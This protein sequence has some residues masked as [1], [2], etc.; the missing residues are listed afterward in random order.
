MCTGREP[1]TSQVYSMKKVLALVLSTIGA[2]ALTGCGNNSAEMA[3][4]CRNRLKGRLKDPFSFRQI[5]KSV[6]Y[7]DDPM[8]QSMVWPAD[9][10]AEY[11]DKYKYM[12]PPHDVYVKIEYT[13]KNGFGGSVRNDF[14]CMYLRKS[15]VRLDGRDVME[16][17]DDLSLSIAR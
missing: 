3:T 17:N 14:K 10:L 2:A 13:A 7:Y 12:I 9:L 5:D 4:D 8:Q 1:D 6:S 16:V 15:L 11:P